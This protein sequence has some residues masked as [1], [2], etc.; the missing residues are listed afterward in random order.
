M[1]YKQRDKQASHVIKPVKET[2]MTQVNLIQNSY[3]YITNI[4]NKT[5][6]GIY[7]TCSLRV[8]FKE[9]VNYTRP[10]SSAPMRRISDDN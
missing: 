4:N 1:R 9:T 5:G 7:I 10:S 6:E 2:A 8:F 3:I